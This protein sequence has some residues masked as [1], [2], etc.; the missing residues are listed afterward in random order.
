MTRKLKPYPAYKDSGV[1]WLVEVPEHWG[2]RRGKTLFRKV[3]RPTSDSDEVVTCF[4][5][6]MVT[7]R[8]NRRVSGF[9][10]A[11]KE[12]GYQGIHRGDLVIHAMDAFAGAIGVSDSD[13]KGSP[14]YSV[15]MPLEGADSKYYAYLTRDMARSQWILALAKGIRERSTDFR[16]EAFGSQFFPLP[17]F[18]EQLAIVRYLDY[19]DR[20]IQRCIRVKQKLIKLLGEQKQAIIHQAVTG[21][22][23][24]RTGKPYPKYKPSRLEWLGSVPEHWEIRRLRSLAQ[25]KTGGKDT[26]DRVDDGEY[27]FYVRSQIV[28]RINSWS[29]DGEAVLTAGDGAGVAKVF[30][31]AEGKFD[32]HQ[33]VY[34][35][36]NFNMLTA[37]FF[38][39]YFRATLH[40]EALAGN[41]K[42]TVDSLRRPM[43]QNFMVPVLSA[44]EQEAIV[45][46][47]QLVNEPSDATIVQASKSIH[48]LR[49]YRTRLI[50]D[51]VTGK[52][53]V[54]EAAASLP[55]EREEELPEDQEHGDEENEDLVDEGSTEEE[56]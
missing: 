22:I 13:G 11:L 43:L 3:Q 4:R 50:S 42:S 34:K 2:L 24:V 53:D 19:M 17:E 35:F 52:L 25:I 16:F 29:F 45:S 40:F 32:Y 12:I 9:T 49:E 54:R 33:R 37:R 39:E 8:K 18:P 26:V 56:E 6:G 30:H 27:P 41:A 15:C 31:Y 10:E 46:H 28:E 36:S 38:F 55:E 48:F 14:V 51:V 1:P 23:D 47:L 5:D 44:E 21:Q 20:R 7:L